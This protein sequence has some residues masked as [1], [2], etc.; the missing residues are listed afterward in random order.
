MSG[1]CG[2]DSGCYDGRPMRGVDSPVL[3]SARG[4]RGQ[5]EREHS[6]R[7]SSHGPESFL[8]QSSGFS[9]I[10]AGADRTRMS[11]S[12][13]HGRGNDRTPEKL[14]ARLS[15]LEAKVTGGFGSTSS[16]VQSES[17]D[18][19][20]DSESVALRQ[21]LLLEERGLQLEHAEVMLKRAADGEQAMQRELLAL[22]EAVAGEGDVRARLAV[23]EREKEALSREVETLGKLAQER[24]CRLD[25]E[26]SGATSL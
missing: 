17:L 13:P 3:R 21:A 25:E 14:A 6:R 12:D 1:E 15:R 10:D 9:R 26:A 11:T 7:R 20:R 16:R 23:V 4:G 24:K 8:D 5:R 2:N 19:Q 18:I 22:K